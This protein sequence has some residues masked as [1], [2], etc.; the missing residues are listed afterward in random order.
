MILIV[1]IILINK[2]KKKMS[3]IVPVF[4]NED[5]ISIL[6]KKILANIK[7]LKIDYEI[8]FIEDCSLDKSYKKIKNICS[9]NKKVVCVKLTKNFGQ[10]YA[11]MAGLK[12]ATGDFLI[13]LDAD[14]Q[15]PPSI[16]SKIYSKFL[17]G[18]KLVIAARK[19]TKDSLF[20]KL[21]SNI[22][23]KLMNYIL[24]NYPREGFTVFGISKEI[25]NKIKAR[26]SNISILQIEIF[27]YGYKH[28]IIYYDREKRLYGKSQMSFKTRA[29]VAIEMFT[30]SPFI[31]LR[32]C[33]YLG[34]LLL[35]ISIIYISALLYSYL[36]FNSPF[37]GYSPILIVSL[38]LGGLNLFILGIISEYISVIL[39]NLKIYEKYNIH[40][41]I[42]KQNN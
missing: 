23:H 7:K 2:M 11:L 25:I 28:E 42:N 34:F 19:S 14:L 16:I 15:D 41:I 8:I 36:T 6:Y 22:Q 17:K 3:I 21:L 1:T 27:N 40:S 29:D 24:S 33:L 38:V 39:K 9:K 13:N 5:T 35:F 18:S 37:K 4:N 31:P 30:Q 32:F 12:Y 10:R 20:N 26:G